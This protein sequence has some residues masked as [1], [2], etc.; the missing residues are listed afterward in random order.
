MAFSETTVTENSG[1]RWEVCCQLF[2][3]E[4]FVQKDILPH[5][6]KAARLR[7]KE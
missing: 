5:G 3:I 6:M 7:V 1:V 2:T 4:K